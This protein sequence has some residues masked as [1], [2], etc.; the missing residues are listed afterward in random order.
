MS[1]DHLVPLARMGSRTDLTAALRCLPAGVTEFHAHP[2]FP[3]DLPDSLAREDD[4]ALYLDGDF[5]AAIGAAGAEL[6]SYRLLR[7]LL[8]S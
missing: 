3:C 7:D 5:R 1:P 8:R 4:L 6:I 2:S